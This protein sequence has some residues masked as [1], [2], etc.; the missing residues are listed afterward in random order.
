MASP[1]WALHA[2]RRPFLLAR[3]RIVAALRELFAARDFVEV[4][5]A[6][7]VLSPGN[8][9]HLHAFATEL[10]APAG[11]R[12]R[13]YLRTSPEF[14]CKKLLA[15]G[16]RRIVEF[17]RVFRNRERSPLHHPEFTLIEWY[18]A[19]GRYE[20]L[21]DDCLAVIARAA[22]EVATRRFSYRERSADP[23]AEAERLTVAQAFER[24]AGID[25][26]STL[27]PQAGDSRRFAMLAHEAGVDS[28]ADDTWGDIFSRVLV[29]KVEPQL[30]F[31]RATILYE[32]PAVMSALARP[33][34]ADRRV[35]ERFEL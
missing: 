35:A 20:L 33:K 1:F 10:V 23:F 13:L 6:T 31:G 24:H 32:Y 3:M 4:E 34:P 18:R 17:A 16:E 27:T 12:A 26:L 22:Q 14:A 11:V 5:T 9:T 21:M 19:H 30:G 8:E 15:A 2:G 25:L 29:E 7:L 28:A